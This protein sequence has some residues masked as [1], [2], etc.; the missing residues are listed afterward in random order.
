[1]VLREL[2]ASPCGIACEDLMFCFCE[3]TIWRSRKAERITIEQGRDRCRRIIPALKL[4]SCLDQF[5]SEC[6]NTGSLLISAL[7]QLLELLP[8]SEDR[9]QISARSPARVS[10]EP[11]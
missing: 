10:N 8:T 1:M 5:R 11:Y 4:E 6:H 2:L 3:N 7:A 9:L